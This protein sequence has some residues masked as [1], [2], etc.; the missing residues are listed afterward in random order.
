MYVYLLY[1]FEV[2]ITVF[3]L[4]K[5]TATVVLAFSHLVLYLNEP[6]ASFWSLY[7]CSSVSHLF[8][9]CFMQPSSFLDACSFSVYRYT[10]IIV[11][12]M[13]FPPIL[14]LSTV[15]THL[16]TYIPTYLPACLPTYLPT[17]LSICLCNYFYLFIYLPT[18]CTYIQYLPTYLPTLTVRVFPDPDHEFSLPQTWSLLCPRP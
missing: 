18:Y 16:P 12:C 11:M 3:I 8:V 9:T 17:Y 13:D 14:N 1:N 2:Q 15:P 5:S 7:F 10:L 6:K 4:V